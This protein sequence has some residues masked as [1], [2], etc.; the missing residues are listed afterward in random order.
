VILIWARWKILR[1]IYFNTA[2]VLAHPD[3]ATDHDFFRVESVIAHEYFHNWTG[4]R[5]TC[6]DWFQLSLKEGLTVYR[7]QEFSADMNS[8]AVQRID[9][10]Q[11][12]RSLQFPEDSG[13][14]AHPVR[15]DN[16]I[17]INN[18]YTTTVY[19][20]GAEVIRMQATLLGP[21]KFRE[22]TDLYFDRFDGQA[23]TCDDFAACMADTGKVDLSQFK[24]WYSQAGTPEITARGHY[25][26]AAQ[27]Y[28]LT[29]SQSVPPT[30]D[31]TEKKPMHIPIAVG[32]LNDNGDEVVSTQV[33]DLTDKSENFI[34]E[35]I[36]SCPVP[37][38]LRNFS[39]PV[40][41]TTD[42]SEDDLRFL[43]VHDT[44]GF[45]RWES[46]QT[47]SLRLIHR[48]LDQIEAGHHAVTDRDYLKTVSMLL[49]QGLD[50]GQD[51]ALLARMLM[52]PDYSSIAQGRHIVDPE[53]IYAVTTKI[54]CDILSEGGKL[55]NDVY[56]AHQ[57]SGAYSPDPDSM[58]RRSLKA[59]VLKF[60][61]ALNDDTAANTAYA[62]Y[63]AADNM[64]DRMM[65]LS[66]LMDS[67]SASREQS[68]EDFY[69]RF[70]AY[71][72]VIDKWFAVQA[73]AVRATTIDD[74]KL[75]SAHPDFT[76]KNPNRARSIY[77][78]FAMMNPV[79]FHRADGKGYEFFGDAV[80]AIDPIN[81][82]VASRLLT[83]VRDWKRYSPAR[84][85]M[86]RTQIERILSREGLSPNS[87]EIAS[88]TI[89]A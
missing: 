80:C 9:D 84:Q 27:T 44:D 73:K 2:L 3:T 19:E 68:L 1:S 63:Q 15:P 55:L 35:K 43:M 60:L 57:S 51:K 54:S 26:S 83:A 69:D 52:L 25:D 29:L 77:S 28:T 71:P 7:D 58:A 18:F 6:R 79:V 37:S 12:L 39:A 11:A 81:P 89:K 8:R 10:V 72:L 65:G 49:E 50:N 5:I 56:A 30:P 67:V 32:L 46:A 47:L 17:E 66:N 62:L 59:S 87:Y 16:Y 24:L 21:Q 76:L 74:L 75:L 13:P 23:V 45:N 64:T 86:I 78:A 14:L 53:A 40:R 34:F 82:Q 41:L 88:K 48:M 38:I 61:T 70:K 31:Q 33:L 20:K 4:N 36:A 22:A 85:D 42:L